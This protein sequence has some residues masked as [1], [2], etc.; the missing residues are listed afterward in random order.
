MG[1]GEGCGRNQETFSLS[2]LCDKAL[3]GRTATLL[4]WDGI[5]GYTYGVYSTSAIARTG[6]GFVCA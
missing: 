3:R 4:L 5:R 2:T 6:R 1:V